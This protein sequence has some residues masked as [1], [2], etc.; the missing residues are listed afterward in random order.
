MQD[1]RPVAYYNRKLNNAQ[2]N[3]ATIHKEFLCVIATLKEF[4]SMLLSAELHTY[5]DHMN[6]LHVGDLSE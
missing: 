1:N 3:Y 4:R 6:I 5:T 2:R